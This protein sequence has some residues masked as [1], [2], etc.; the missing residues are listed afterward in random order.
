MSKP[1]INFIGTFDRIENEDDLQPKPG[2]NINPPPS[3][4]RCDCCGRHISE[5]KPFGGPGDP[6]VGNF[7]GSFLVKGYRNLG[8]YDADAEK[9]YEEAKNRYEADGFD[10]PLD[11]MIDK[12]GKEKAEDLYYANEGYYQVGSSWECRDCMVLDM[13]DYFKKLEHRN[14]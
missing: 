14:K 9:A 8:S 2:I 11:W 5:L 13:D 12:Y 10:D 1:Q 6:L 4:G 7:T 3:D